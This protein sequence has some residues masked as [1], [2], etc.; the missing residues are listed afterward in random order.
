MAA[1]G[2]VDFRPALE[3]AGRFT[4]Q[5]RA[6]RGHACRHALS[7]PGR[8]LIALRG[9]SLGQIDRTYPAGDGNGGAEAL[10]ALQAANINGGQA[11]PC[12]AA[13]PPVSKDS[14]R[15]GGE[16]WGIVPV[17]FR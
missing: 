13:G 17:P 11:A 4:F 5:P 8:Q 6:D 15:H 1:V 9:F 3:A 10:V 2:E 16:L 7:R 14:S 12:R